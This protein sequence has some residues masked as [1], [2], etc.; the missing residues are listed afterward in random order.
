MK[1]ATASIPIS[2]VASPMRAVGCGGP[3]AGGV[4]ARSGP[5]RSAPTGTAARHNWSSPAALMKASA[6][7]PRVTVTVPASCPTEGGRGCWSCRS[8][9]RACRS[10]ACQA[11]ST[12]ALLS[13]TL[14]RPTRRGR[15]GDG[16]DSIDLQAGRG[17]PE[18]AGWTATPRDHARL[19][20]RTAF[21]DRQ[22]MVTR[23]W[24]PAAEASRPRSRTCNQLRTPPATAS[25][26]FRLGG[27]A[28]RPY[29]LHAAARGQRG[30]TEGFSRPHP[31][32]TRAAARRVKTTSW[33]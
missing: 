31:H 27:P 15:A 30:T 1:P 24:V 23:R 14:S 21:G 17:S 16:R 25:R 2:T 28:R 13:S 20:A 32:G 19:S 8:R 11:W 29:L 7:Q 4:R 10:R 6:A 22:C 26:S 33:A 18:A 12:C 3:A 9:D 5:G